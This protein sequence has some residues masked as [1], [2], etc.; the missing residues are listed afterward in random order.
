MF[1]AHAPAAYLLGQ[2]LLPDQLDPH[3]YLIGIAIVLFGGL[4]PDLDL[5]YFYFVDHR[6]HVH[7]SY[8]THIPFYWVSV[9]GLL[10]VPLWRWWGRVAVQRFT[11]LVCG[12]MLHMLLDSVASGILWLYPFD[13]NYI[14][15]WHIPARYDWWVANYLL[16]WTFLLELVIVAASVWAF[17]KDRPLRAALGRLFGVPRTRQSLRADTGREPQ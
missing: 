10:V 5:L 16:H 11:L 14:G 4:A 2:R 9:Y 12:G 6:Q 7:H 1:I 17:R 3:R 15:L 8:C 13:N